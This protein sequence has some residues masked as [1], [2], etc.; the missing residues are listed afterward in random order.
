MAL[1]FNVELSA[2]T[3]FYFS[4]GVL[5]RESCEKEDG[6][7]SGESVEKWRAQLL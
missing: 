6:S 2:S 4:F 3:T 7:R 5:F 1:F